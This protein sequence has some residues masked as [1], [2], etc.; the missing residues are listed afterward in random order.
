MEL[1]YLWVEEYKNIKKQG[2]NFS[3]RFKCHYDENTNELTIDEN[4]EYERIFPENIN[5]TAIVG[6]NGSGKSSILEL[7][8]ELSYEDIHIE[9]DYPVSFFELIQIIVY[10]DKIK[11]KFYIYKHN[12]TATINNQSSIVEEKITSKSIQKILISSIPSHSQKEYLLLLDFLRNNNI[13]FPFSTPEIINICIHDDCNDLLRLIENKNFDFNYYYNIFEEDKT[14]KFKIFHILLL[15]AYLKNYKVDFDIQASKNYDDTILELEKKIDNDI[16][17]K[18]K[19]FIETPLENFSVTSHHYVNI[20]K[21]SNNFFKTYMEITKR[22]ETDKLHDFIGKNVFI[23]NVYPQMSDGQYQLMYIL[24][25]IYSQ[26]NQ[27]TIMLCIDEGENYLHPNWQKKYV[28]YLYKFLKD[29]FSNKQIHLIISSHSPFILSDLPKENVIFLEQG[30]Q[31]YPF[32]DNQQTFGANIHTLLSHGF[33]MED[34]L[35]GEFAKSKINEI[36][37]FHNR[38]KANNIDKTALTSEYENQKIQFWH[39]QNIVGDDY[40]K[41]VIKNHLIEIEKILLGKDGAKSEEITR[42]RAY[43]KSLEN[44]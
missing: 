42:A 25:A 26:I 29:N 5:V 38:T 9:K 23:F 28:N 37:E 43:L 39:I 40:L 34:G 6:E 30:K 12:I 35:M 20:K 11:N 36:I 2:F 32:G 8:N 33:F 44:D 10:Y 22:K 16:K 27:D 13:D 31:V 1:V 41:Q 15:L 17:I 24:N 21:I 7:I 14:K 4:K 18:I 3:P 19:D